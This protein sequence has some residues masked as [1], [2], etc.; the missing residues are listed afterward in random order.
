MSVREQ[1]MAETQK[2]LIEVARGA[3]AEYGYTDTSMDK[4]TAKRG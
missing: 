1:R 2:K 4:L 3:F